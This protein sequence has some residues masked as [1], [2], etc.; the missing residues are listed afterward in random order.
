M[1][2]GR[3]VMSAGVPCTVSEAG[4][5]VSSRHLQAPGEFDFCMSDEG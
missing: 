4:Q 3:R 1:L 2:A 5:N